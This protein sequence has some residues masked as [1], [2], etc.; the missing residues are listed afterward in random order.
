MILMFTVLESDLKHLS[1]RTS[2]WR[3]GYKSSQNWRPRYQDS[4]N[5][6]SIYEYTRLYAKLKIG[7]L[8]RAMSAQ[9][10]K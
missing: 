7:I 2:H 9:N 5:E 8:R 10:E 4:G 1:G 6:I 3:T